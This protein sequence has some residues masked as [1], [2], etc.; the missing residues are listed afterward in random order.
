MEFFC[1]MNSLHFLL[2]AQKEVKHLPVL[3]AEYYLKFSKQTARKINVP[4]Y[5]AHHA[6]IENLASSTPSPTSFSGES[7]QKR[8]CRQGQTTQKEKMAKAR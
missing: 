8:Q 4:W 1:K 3:F 5:Y 2:K 7:L 6:V